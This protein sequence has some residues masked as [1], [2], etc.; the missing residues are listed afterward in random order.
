[1]N[2][3]EIERE[4]YKAL[5]ESLIGDDFAKTFKLLL[6]PVEFGD[7]S[8]SISFKLAKVLKKSPTDIANLI[9]QNLKSEYF[10]TLSNDKG[11]INIRVNSK[12]Y[13]E[14]I[15]DLLEKKENYFYFPSTGK[16]IQVEFISANPT[17]P[18]HVGNG[19]G[20]AIGDVVANLLKTRGYSVEREYYVN[21]AGNKMD[22]LGASIRFFYLERFG[23][24]V[25]FP[26]E[27]YKG[28]YIKAVSDKISAVFGDRFVHDDEKKQIETFKLL[29]EYLLF[30]K[31]YKTSEEIEIL[32]NVPPFEI[33]SIL[34]V[35]EKF[36]IQYDNVFFESS[37]YE[38]KPK[39]FEGT[40]S[41]P[42]K[43]VD[44]LE[45][46]KERG[47][48]YELDGAFWFKSTAFGDD[49]DRVLVKA[50]GEPT[51]TLTDIAYHIDKF[52]RGFSKVID[53]WGADHF[54]HVTTMKALLE[55]VGIG[56]DFLDVILYQIVHLFEEGTEVMMSK[57]TGKFYTLS[58]LIKEVGKDAARFFFLMKSADSHLNFDIDLAKKESVDN[59]V[60]YVQYT[61]ARFNN[62]I[63]EAEK[64]KIEFVNIEEISN[65]TYEPIERKILDEIFYFNNYLDDIASNYSIHRVT[66]LLIDFSKDLNFF[67][68]NY[69]VL[70]EE[71]ILDR[72]KRFLIV[73]SALITLSLLFDILGIEKREK[74]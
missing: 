55:G 4:V 58:E 54:G 10:E 27:G 37:L 50:T 69:R 11:Y 44:V 71:N 22:L 63:S 12:F 26:E 41:L 9:I 66:N 45:I 21:D 59:P 47:D 33:D 17:G 62:I 68:Q 20:G 36:G 49:K 52:N 16:K 72:T 32:K 60:Y 74:M 24:E 64:R 30:G 35:L 48:L 19:R 15:Q 18:L 28:D 7:F 61:Y 57:H 34:K 65:V 31:T 14:F 53:V 13:K 2:I 40:V 73:E 3:Y 29:G 70:G 51:Y 56:K 5:P 1:M 38:G 43:L 25:E 42:P 46:L 67:Y 6:A 39:V 8:L 23:I